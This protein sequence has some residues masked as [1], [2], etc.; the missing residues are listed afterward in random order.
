MSYSWATMHTAK[1]YAAPYWAT[2]HPTEFHCIL[3]CAPSELC[4]TPLSCACILLSYNTPYWAALHPGE[5]WCS[6]LSY[7]LPPYWAM[8]YPSEHIL[9]L[10]SNAAPYWAPGHSTEL[11]QYWA[12]LYPTE[13]RWTLLSY[14]EPY[15]AT[16]NPTELRCT[17]L[18]YAVLY[19][20]MPWELHYSLTELPS[21]LVPFLSN[22]GLS[23]TEI[24]VPQ[25][26]T[27]MLRY[28]TEMLDAG[29]TMPAAL[30]S[31]PMPTYASSR[32]ALFSV[33]CPFFPFLF[34]ALLL[35]KLSQVWNLLLSLRQASSSGLFYLVFLWRKC[36][37]L[38][39]T[40]EPLIACSASF[41]KYHGI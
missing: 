14:A 6:L 8:L 26:G 41:F 21:V 7:P 11:L 23:C 3:F 13:L 10:L 5:L 37:S 15:W 35:F 38:S 17:L 24:R 4:C 27:G 18:S 19:W 1:L 2:L 25:S 9:H 33:L 12:T 36:T 20:A 16:L 30:A 29:I 22:A 34:L 39:L 40:R 32:L 31:M 28:R